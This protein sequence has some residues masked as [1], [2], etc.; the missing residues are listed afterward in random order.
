VTFVQLD[1]PVARIER[2]G[3][4]WY[5]QLRRSA[6]GARYG[7]GTVTF[8]EHQGEARLEIPGRV[9]ICRRKPSS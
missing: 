7:D 3:A 2:A 1:P 6:S 9:V 8:W 4:R 5:L